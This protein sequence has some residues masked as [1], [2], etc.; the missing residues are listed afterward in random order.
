MF[1]PLHVTFRHSFMSAELGALIEREAEKLGRLCD[2][3]SGVSVVVDQ[4][5]HHRRVGGSFL[6]RIEIDLPDRRLVASQ[7]RAGKAGGARPEVALSEAFRAAQ[8]SLRRYTEREAKHA[9]Q[10]LSVA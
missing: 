3:I 6:A 10:R 5:D 8:R 1:S 4:P 7:R 9:R 2:R